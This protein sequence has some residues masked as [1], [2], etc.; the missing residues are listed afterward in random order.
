MRCLNANQMVFGTRKKAKKT[1]DDFFRVFVVL[2]FIGV[3]INV[4]LYPF[5]PIFNQ[6]AAITSHFDLYPPQWVVQSTKQ[7]SVACSSAWNEEKTKKSSGD[8]CIK[9]FSFCFWL[10]WAQQQ[11]LSGQWFV[12][13]HF[14]TFSLLRRLIGNARRNGHGSTSSPAKCFD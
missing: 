12:C 2:L 5:Y 11:T 6:L 3:T 13:R 1:T 9:M 4:S 8:G 14:I 10:R 7:L